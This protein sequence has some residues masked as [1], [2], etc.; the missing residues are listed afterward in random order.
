MLISTILNCLIYLNSG[1]DKSIWHCPKSPILIYLILTPSLK[2]LEDTFMPGFPYKYCANTGETKQM[3][4]DCNS[5]LGYKTKAIL[6]KQKNKEVE[7]M[8]GNPLGIK[9][10]K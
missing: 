7:G 6:T 2:V 10:A 9:H 1:V 3:L 4:E 8:G 5:N